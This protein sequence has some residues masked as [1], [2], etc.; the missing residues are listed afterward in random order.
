MSMSCLRAFVAVFLLSLSTFATESD[1]S[2]Y[3]PL[4]PGDAWTMDVVLTD[5]N[6][7]VDKTILHREIEAQVEK[8]GKTYVPVSSWVEGGPVRS[9]F[10]KLYR[11]DAEGL[12]SIVEGAMEQTEI[13]LPI[14]VGNTWK[15][16]AAGI[17]VTETVIGLETVAIE[18]RVYKNCFHI[19]TQSSNGRYREDFWEAP[20]IGRVKSERVFNN[21][22]KRTATLRE[23]K[24]G[25]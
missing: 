19:R 7:R 20:R 14:I 6:G 8:F 16:Q 18:D 3:L 1:Q 4:I 24:P 21:H 22:V 25:R 5:P 11:K 10:A 12:Y 17:M 2:D 15:W 23:F 13:P 9:P